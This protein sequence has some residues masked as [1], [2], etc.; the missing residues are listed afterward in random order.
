M[1][2]VSKPFCNRAC[3]HSFLEH[4][5]NKFKGILAS[6]DGLKGRIGS[7]RMSPFNSPDSNDE[8]GMNNASPVLISYQMT[9]IRKI[10]VVR[11][12]SRDSQL[13]VPNDSRYV[14][15]VTNLRNGQ[16]KEGYKQ[17]S[18]TLAVIERALS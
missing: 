12:K 18:Y 8:N 4:V 16:A 9:D 6:A 10:W 14:R 2:I 3:D 17:S 15:L 11:S 1:G 13:A 5:T 7:W